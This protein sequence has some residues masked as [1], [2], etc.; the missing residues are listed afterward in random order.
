[1]T[2]TQE[3]PNNRW[4]REILEIIKVLVISLAIVLPIRYY[5]AQPFIVRGASMEPNFHD[6]EYLIVDEVSYLLQEPKRGEAIV[7]RYPLGPRQFFIKRIIGLPGEGVDIK[8]GRVRVINNAYPEGFVLEEPYLT[9]PGRATRPDLRIKLAQGEY[10]VMGDNRDFS[11]DSRVW[12]TL[13]KKFIVGRALFRAL[14][15]TSL[16]FVANYA[17]DY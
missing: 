12:G 4:G 7:F 1:M 17:V 15:V 16:G 13:N 2:E 10:F 3:N 8:N 9:P 6:K 5:I 14:P 11:S